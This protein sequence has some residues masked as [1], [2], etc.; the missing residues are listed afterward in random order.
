V[1]TVRQAI[2]RNT[3]STKLVPEIIDWHAPI[4]IQCSLLLLVS[5]I[6]SSDFS[7]T[8]WGTDVR[9]NSCAKERRGD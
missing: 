1:V 9:N 6:R 8:H 2:E 3:D 4:S 5:F 7:D